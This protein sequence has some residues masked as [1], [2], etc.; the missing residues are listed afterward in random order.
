MEL[1]LRGQ[2]PAPTQPPGEA[3]F[4]QVRAAVTS[5]GLYRMQTGRYYVALSLFEAESLRG[6]LHAAAEGPGLWPAGKTAVALRSVHSH[7]GPLDVSRGYP[8]IAAA[9]AEHHHLIATQ[10]F[11]YLDCRAGP[12]GP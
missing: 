7:Y 4:E 11:R 2:P 6:V 8:A 3:T 1:L 9:P 5:Q 12:G 10:C